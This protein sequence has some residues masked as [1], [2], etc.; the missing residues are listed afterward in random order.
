MATED[1]KIWVLTFSTGHFLP[2]P[3]PNVS[4]AEMNRWTFSPLYIRKYLFFITCHQTYY[5]TLISNMATPVQ[6]VHSQSMKIMCVVR[7]VIW[8]L[9]CILLYLVSYIALLVMFPRSIILF[10]ILHYWLCSYKVLS[11]FLYCTI[12]VMFPQSIILF[13]ILHDWL[14][15]H[16]VLSCF[17]YCT[18]GYVPIKYYLVSYIALLVMFPQSILF[19]YIARLVMFPQSIILFLILHYW[20][21]P[22]NVLSCFFYCTIGYVPMNYFFHKRCAKIT[23]QFR[24]ILSKNINYRCTSCCEVFPFQNISNDEIIFENSSVEDNYEIYKLMDNCSQFKFNSFKY[25][26]YNPYDFKNDTD[27]EHNFYTNLSSKCQYYRLIIHR[28]NQ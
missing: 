10:V 8:T 16:K 19:S 25:S 5:M 3:C 24:L 2:L 20:L 9:F 12:L 17:L 28:E 7:A 15:S 27:P 21:C 26:D 6:T 11:C 13:L 22:H 23:Q 1:G 14:C 4:N 18:I